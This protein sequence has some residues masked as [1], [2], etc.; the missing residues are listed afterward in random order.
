[1]V[2]SVC[3]RILSRRLRES[4]RRP[5]KREF[6]VKEAAA[7]GKKYIIGLFI[8][9]VSFC[10]CFYDLIMQPWQCVRWRKSKKK[11]QQQLNMNEF[12]TVCWYAEQFTVLMIVM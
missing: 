12:C 8:V 5:V 1:M 10:V 3:V 9:Y 6:R 2:Y 11:K 4:E 7:P